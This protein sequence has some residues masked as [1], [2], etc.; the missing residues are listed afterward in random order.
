MS[1]IRHDAIYLAFSYAFSLKD[2]RR[3][4]N[5]VP[6]TLRD[7]T[8]VLNSDLPIH[9]ATGYNRPMADVQRHR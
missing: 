9:V 4:K 3:P 7:G 8:K 2:G 6:D 5:G 1:P